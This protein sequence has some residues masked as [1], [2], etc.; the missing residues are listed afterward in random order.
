MTGRAPPRLAF[1]LSE[2]RGGLLPERLDRYRNAAGRLAELAA[3]EVVTSHYTEADA[4]DA[5]AVVLSGSYDPWDAHDPHELDRFRAVLRA[6]ERPAFGI[7]A[8]MQLLA[9]ATGG[10]VAP[11]AIATERGFADVD[12][13]DGSDLLAGLQP[14]ISVLEHHTDEITALPDGF[15]VLARSET[16][17]VEAL[18]AE[19][20]LWWGTQFHPEEWTAEHPAGRAIL[21]N[22]LR[23]AGIGVR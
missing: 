4:L 16:C 12:V 8:G 23:L 17:A 21:E 22:F 2:H 13:L 6:C 1:V 20:R 15:R 9:T 11:A 18:A 7:C 14:R 19:D 10:E 5:D 3:A